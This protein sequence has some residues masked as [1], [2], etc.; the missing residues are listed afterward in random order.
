MMLC[1]NS[2]HNISYNKKYI[3]L[4]EK[5]SNFYTIED[6]LWCKF[7]KL[8]TR[9]CKKEKGYVKGKD[10]VKIVTTLFVTTFDC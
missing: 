10:I 5:E 6:D 7:V 1:D 2:F 8:I 3:E 9:K 4:K